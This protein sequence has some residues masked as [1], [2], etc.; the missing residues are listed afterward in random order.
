VEH[1]KHFSRVDLHRLHRTSLLE[2]AGP[3]GELA[4]AVEMSLSVQA[5]PISRDLKAVACPRVS[6]CNAVG[7]SGTILARR[8]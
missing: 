4:M 7:A 6:A 2:L 1:Q 8:R 5:S 3:H